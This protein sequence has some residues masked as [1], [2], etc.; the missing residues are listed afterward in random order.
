M[1]GAER[2]ERCEGAEREVLLEA[3]DRD[4]GDGV[5]PDDDR[6]VLLPPPLLLGDEVVEG[7]GGSFSRDCLSLWWICS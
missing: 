6:L 4:D 5:E 3:A 7:E 2:D 1:L